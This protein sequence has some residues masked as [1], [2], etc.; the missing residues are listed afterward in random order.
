MQ[1][2]V[3]NDEDEPIAIVTGLAG[4]QQTIE[5]QLGKR[6]I[7]DDGKEK[8]YTCFEDFRIYELGGPKAFTSSL[9]SMSD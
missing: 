6:V 5:Q 9:T 7:C 1:Y 8:F 3:A 4:V 2:L